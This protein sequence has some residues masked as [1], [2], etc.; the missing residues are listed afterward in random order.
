MEFSFETFST[1]KDLYINSHKEVYDQPSD[2]QQKAF[3]IY[4]LVFKLL[5][6]GVLTISVL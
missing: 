2:T 5:D 3:I 4:K 6:A 1:Y